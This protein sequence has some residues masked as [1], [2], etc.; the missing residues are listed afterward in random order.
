M[1]GPGADDG[2]KRE[3]ASCD[4]KGDWPAGKD[5]ATSPEE[6]ALSDSILV[7][8][9][10]IEGIT[11][12]LRNLAFL[13]FEEYIAERVSLKSSGL[14]CDWHTRDD[15]DGFHKDMG[16]GPDSS[17]CFLMAIRHCIFS[18]ESF[19]KLNPPR[20]PQPGTTHVDGMTKS[21]WLTLV[22]FK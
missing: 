21:L 16:P 19:G 20:P 17:A 1:D 15:A 3:A 7:D 13:G 6:G 12:A 18:S 9:G 4:G 11:P 10:K 2:P 22:I 5:D 14:K 8:H